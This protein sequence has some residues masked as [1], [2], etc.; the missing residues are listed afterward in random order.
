M[1]ALVPPPK[2]H[3]TVYSGV[4]SSH[5]QWCN[6]IIPKTEVV[7]ENP[8]LENAEQSDL[9]AKVIPGQAGLA[10]KKPKARMSKYIPLAW[11]TGSRFCGGPL[12]KKLCART[13]ANR[14]G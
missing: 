13:V 4:L 10:E 8:D 11:A 5:S 1:A 12:V 9:P 3:V 14:C 7:A 2:R 6:L